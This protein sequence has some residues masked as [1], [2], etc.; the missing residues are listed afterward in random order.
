MTILQFNALKKWKFNQTS[1]FV[2]KEFHPEDY[3]FVH[4]VACSLG[5]GHVERACKAELIEFKDKQVTIRREKEKQKAAK[6]AERDAWLAFLNR[7]ENVEDVT[8]AMTVKILDDQLEIYRELVAGIPLKSKLK[9]KDMKM[10]ALRNAIRAFQ[11]QE[12][13]SDN[14][15]DEE[16]A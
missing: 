14:E 11:T 12:E 9:N 4:K 10:E 16:E 7:V 1:S 3:V 6:K 2:K 8:K 15:G 13:G 5:T